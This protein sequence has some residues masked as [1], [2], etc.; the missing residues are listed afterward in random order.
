MTRFIK[1]QE[2]VIFCGRVAC[3]TP[4][5]WRS[6]SFEQDAGW[7]WIACDFALAGWW[8]P[9]RGCFYSDDPCSLGNVSKLGQQKNIIMIEESTTLTTLGG[10]PPGQ[11]GIPGIWAQWTE[12]MGPTWQFAIVWLA[13]ALADSG[14]K[15]GQV[16][17]RWLEA[18]PMALAR[19]ARVN[20]YTGP[21]SGY[22]EGLVNHLKRPRGAG[23]P[24]HNSTGWL[25]KM[26]N[27]SH[28]PTVVDSGCY[29]VGRTGHLKS[30]KH[31]GIMDTL[32]YQW[33]HPHS[34]FGYYIIYIYIFIYLWIY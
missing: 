24:A 11:V 9:L 28:P 2:R 23:Q 13:V 7:R 8:K 32:N 10:H 15:D 1:L 30:F 34:W 25:L 16:L 19:L 18:L 4:S 3:R 22:M 17:S 33:N 5:T 29:R 26:R 27:P 6:I 12:P 20:R 21:P 14:R 31:G